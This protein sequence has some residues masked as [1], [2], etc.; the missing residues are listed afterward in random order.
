MAAFHV[1]DRLLGRFYLLVGNAIG[2]SIG[3]FALAISL[4]L[5]MRLLNL[6]NLPGIQEI[7]EYFLFAGVFLGS[8]WVLRLG[9]H[10]RVD[11]FVA[12]L[13]PGAAMW[14]NRALDLFGCLVCSTLVVFG[15]INLRDAYVFNSMQMKYYNVPE[16][17]LLS[18]FVF[19]FALLSIEFLLRLIRSGSPQEMSQKS[20]RGV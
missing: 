10:I 18:V 4:D 14:V 13:S 1:L 7:I 11:V 5:V 9:S 19:G 2:V 12:S 3:I 8:P 20:G 15:L 16:W 17:W 6:G